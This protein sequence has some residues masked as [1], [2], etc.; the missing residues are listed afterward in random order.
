[1]NGAREYS[2]LF[3]TGQHGRFYFVS[4]SH[5]RGNTF[6]VFLLPRDTIAIPNGDN[7]PPLNSDIVE[8]YGV[9]SGNSGWNEEYGWIHHGPWERDFDCIVDNKRTEL[10][11]Q[12]ERLE[13]AQAVAQQYEKSRIAV[14]LSNYTA[15]DQS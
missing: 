2:E 8:I 3:A 11:R 1:M 5:A 6:R 12:S 9:V 7:N 15:S 4:S 14:L 10:E 13:Q